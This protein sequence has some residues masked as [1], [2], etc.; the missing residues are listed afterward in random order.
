MS[1]SLLLIA[2]IAAAQ[3]QLSCDGIT[4]QKG[5][6]G[7]C[8]LGTREADDAVVNQC[9]AAICAMLDLH[10][11]ASGSGRQVSGP[12]YN[13][14][15]A[16]KE[17]GTMERI[18]QI[19]GINPPG[20]NPPPSGGDGGSSGGLTGGGVFLIVF[21]VGFFVYFAAGSAYMYKVKGETGA[22][23]VPNV[24]FWKGLPGLM[25]DGASFL[26]GKITGSGSEGPYQT[27]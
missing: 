3:A 1:R 9:A 17:P 7:A 16:D 15:V 2:G 14:A 10:D 6:P 11:I 4:I 23:A 26:K 12:G 13:C 22:N 5:Q 19:S 20:P 24:A 21:F 27:V 25:K 18:C 8:G